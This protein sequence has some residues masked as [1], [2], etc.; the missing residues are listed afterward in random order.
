M[1]VTNDLEFEQT[2]YR[3]MLLL[4]R[5]EEATGDA[6]SR[7]EI[8]GFTHLYLWQEAVAVGVC[9]QLTSADQITSTHRGHGHALAKGLE[10]RALMAELY[11]RS[12]GVVGGRGG[13][14][15]LYQP[16]LGLLG[17]NGIVASGGGLACGAALAAKTR[18][19][20]GIAVTFM[21]D[22]ATDHG[23]THEAMNFAA[24][25]EL[26]V[27]FVV[28]NNGFSEGTPL[29]AHAARTDLAQR[30]E[31]YGMVGVRVDGQDV[32]AVAEATR[33]AVR[34]ARK[35]SAPTLIEAVTLRKTGHFVGDQMNY[36]L[37][38]GWTAFG[39]DPLEMSRQRLTASGV[40]DDWFTH[41]ADE[42]DSVVGDS[43]EFA[44]QSPWPD[45]REVTSHLFAG[46]NNR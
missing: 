20:D 44:R 2:L 6:F 1:T 35:Q 21:G 4:R 31:I 33:E 29:A 25:L 34:R 23:A 10:P 14:M 38:E 43:I 7:G 24:V 9:S 42:I 39:R 17:T 30:A 37:P 16:E 45:A 13:S 11:G 3:E 19:T 26:P 5:F 8:P 28:E 46:E 36:L 18:G 12:T 27:I 15:H 41:I 40:A 32:L 22:G